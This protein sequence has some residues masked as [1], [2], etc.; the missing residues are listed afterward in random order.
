[1]SE[2]KHTP[3]PWNIL[4]K[5]PMQ[6]TGNFHQVTDDDRYPAAFIPAWDN[7]GPGEEDGTEE[8]LANARLIATAPELLEALKALRDECM[9][10]VPNCA[11][12][13]DAAISKAEGRK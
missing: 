13:V 12:M 11:E 1:M 8:A 2:M 6:M 5:R 9:G 7:P 10:M 3:G 4:R